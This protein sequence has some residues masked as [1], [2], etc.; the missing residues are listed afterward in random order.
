VLDLE[1][2]VAVDVVL[3]GEAGGLVGGRDVVLR[4]T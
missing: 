3:V 2:A 4:R 1:G